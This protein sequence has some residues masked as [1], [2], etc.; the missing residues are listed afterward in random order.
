MPFPKRNGDIKSM[1]CSETILWDLGGISGQ[2]DCW[3]MSLSLGT[4]NHAPAFWSCANKMVTYLLEAATRPESHGIRP[5]SLKVTTIHGLM[6][7]VGKGHSDISQLAIQGNYKG[8][9]AQYVD[10][11]YSRN[12]P[13]GKSP[14]L[15]SHKAL[16]RKIMSLCLQ[17]RG[18]RSLRKDNAPKKRLQ[19]PNFWDTS[20]VIGL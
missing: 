7:E 9:A 13:I 3:C 14:C 19:K 6:T 17:H 4:F 16:F 20:R 5:H 1:K 12:P 15:I 2:V 10:R 8:V 18:H 11:C